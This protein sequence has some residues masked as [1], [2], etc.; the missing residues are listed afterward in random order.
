MATAGT[1]PLLDDAHKQLKE[2][3][4]RVV[5]VSDETQTAKDSSQQSRKESMEAR[6]KKSAP[7]RRALEDVFRSTK[8]VKK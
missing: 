6:F 1:C 5:N 2:M 4:F 7:E 3:T 8:K